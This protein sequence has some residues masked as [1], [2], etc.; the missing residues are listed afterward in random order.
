MINWIYIGRIPF[1]N[2][3]CKGSFEEAPFFVKAFANWHLVSIQC[4]LLTILSSKCCLNIAVSILNLFSVTFFFT[5]NKASY[6]KIYCQYRFQL[7]Y[8]LPHQTLLLKL[9]QIAA[10][11]LLRTH[12]ILLDC[13][14]KTEHFIFSPAKNI[15]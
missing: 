14:L 9:T 2:I 15:K 11:E 7:E 13:Q 3:L 8:V 10:K 5:V 6:L 1:C 12:L 4:N